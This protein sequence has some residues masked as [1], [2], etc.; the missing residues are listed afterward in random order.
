MSTSVSE[1]ALAAV[2]KQSYT[3][4]ATIAGDE[5]KVAITE[6]DTLN[7]YIGT[8]PITELTT[9]HRLLADAQLV[10]DVIERLAYGGDN[11]GVRVKIIKRAGGE[12]GAPA[13]YISVAAE[14]TLCGKEMR[15]EVVIACNGPVEKSE[16][17][18]QASMI[19]V[20]RAEIVLLNARIQEVEEE[21]KRINGHRD[22]GIIVIPGQQ[23]LAVDLRDGCS[24]WPNV[25]GALCIISPHISAILF[26]E[27]R[28]ATAR[29]WAAAHPELPI[30]AEFSISTNCLRDIP[31]FNRVVIYPAMGKGDKGE[32]L[33]PSVAKEFDDRICSAIENK[34]IEFISIAAEFKYRSWGTAKI[35]IM[36]GPYDQPRGFGPFIELLPASGEAQFRLK[37]VPVAR[38]KSILRR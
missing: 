1:C 34:D 3:L 2:N 32:S 17:E 12:R 27:T 15:D 24:C 7:D 19:G 26:I 5:L 29:Q 20:L 9:K 28:D 33:P 22:L 8:M 4:T 14:A 21:N 10:R 13:W 11:D 6:T 30:G 16:L 23:A 25:D 36:R 31:L 37:A 38:G 35:N 18:R